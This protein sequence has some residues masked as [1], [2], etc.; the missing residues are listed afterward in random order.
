MGTAIEYFGLGDPDRVTEE[1]V[2]EPG[3][4]DA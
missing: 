4:G 2:G 3:E 1:P